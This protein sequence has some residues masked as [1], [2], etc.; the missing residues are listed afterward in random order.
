MAFTNPMLAGEELTQPAIRSNNYD[1]GVAGWRIAADGAAEFDNLGVRGEFWAPQIFLNGQDLNTRINRL[2]LGCMA[3]IG[4]YPTT[5]TTTQ[6]Q[7]FATEVQV[8][9]GRWYDI[10]LIGV[11][12]DMGSTKGIEYHIRYTT[13]GS[14]VTNT[15]PILA[16]SL[17]LSQFEMG[18]VRMFYAAPYTGTMKLRASIV[19][20]DGATV[21]NWSPGQGGILAAYD[22]GTSPPNPTGT[23]GVGV[24]TRVLKEFTITA[25]YSK[26]FLGD[27]SHRTDGNYQYTMIMG[28][29]SNGKGQQRGWCT[30]STS[31]VATY[32]DD[33]I[34][35]PESDIVTAELKLRAI[36]QWKNADNT[37][38]VS[39][40][41]HNSH[42]PLPAGGEPGGGI[43]NVCRY[44]LNGYDPF[45]FNLKPGEGRPTNFLD[46]MRDGYLNGFMVG[47][48]F[49]GNIYCGI[50]A[51][52]YYPIAEWNTPPQLH[53]KY[54]KLQ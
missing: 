40:G 24:P 50:L 28:D 43:P 16:I 4:G 26:T 15:S 12:P 46:S 7:I 3:W 30:F 2:P 29:W 49:A 48:T 54:Y 6:A 32:L 18:N 31:D 52:A 25:Q 39:L 21:R 13:D 10:A 11:T 53:M 38:I 33:L 19:S 47:N 44:Y 36:G 9:Q 51:G 1:P 20:L 8:T 5:S 42:G 37:G 14:A 22:L 41:F 27:G 34:N 35:V 23:V 17:R 45:W